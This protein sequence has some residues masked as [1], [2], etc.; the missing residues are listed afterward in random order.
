MPPPNDPQEVTGQK[1]PKAYLAAIT[2]ARGD[3]P[4]GKNGHD[5]RRPLNDIE[6]HHSAAAILSE[7]RSISGEIT[8]ASVPGGIAMV[9]MLFSDPGIVPRTRHRK[10]VR[11]AG[12]ARRRAGPLEM[13]WQ[14]AL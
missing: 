11:E 8:A 12:R 2:V 4:G 10:P 1:Q 14:S 7:F 6:F 9:E 13:L 5:H 3:E